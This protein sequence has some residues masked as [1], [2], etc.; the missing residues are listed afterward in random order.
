MTKKII[1]IWENDSS[2][3][4]LCESMAGEYDEKPSVEPPLHPNCECKLITK[5]IEEETVKYD[6][7]GR[8]I[9]PADSEK[10]EYKDMKTSKKGIDFIIKNEGG[11]KSENGF[12]I[13]YYC[14]AD[15][16]TIGYGHVIK[17]KQEVKKYE[18][19][20]TQNEALLLL[21]KDLKEYEKVINQNI[22]KQLNQNEFDSL[23]SFV[24]NIGGSE[25]R[26]KSSVKRIINNE[27]NPGPNYKTLKDAFGAYNKIWD[28]NSKRMKA[29]DGLSTRREKEWL[30]FKK[31]IY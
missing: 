24:Y 1:W 5:E 30:L 21:K 25:F 22:T 18:N 12:F 14:A 11:A 15:K 31:G 10:K 17:D 6:A 2:P 3:C 8:M 9:N 16:L 20:I 29:N 28:S 19:G 27:N 4:P 23:V 26:N 7:T 13:P